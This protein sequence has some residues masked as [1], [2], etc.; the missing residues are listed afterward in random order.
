MSKQHPPRVT[1]FDLALLACMERR[2]AEIRASM[3]A[4]RARL[5]LPPWPEGTP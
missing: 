3:G 2:L 5:K 1:L 4:R